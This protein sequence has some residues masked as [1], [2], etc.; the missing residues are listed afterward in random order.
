MIWQRLSWDTFDTKTGNT[1]LDNNK[2]LAQTRIC[3]KSA[4]TCSPSWQRLSELLALQSQ[5]S[6]ANGFSAFPI[7]RN[8]DAQ[9]HIIPLYEAINFFLMQQM[10]KAVV[11]YGPH[12][13]FTKE[14]LNAMTSSVENFIPYDW[15]ILIK[16]L[17]KPRKY[18]Q[19][20]MWFHD[21]ARDHANKNA[22]D[23]AS[24]NQ[25]IFEMLTD[26]RQ[27]DAIE[28][29]IQ[30]PPLLHEQLKTVALEVWDQITPQGEPT[31]SYTKILQGPNKNYSDFFS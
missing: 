29:Q 15:K 17:L 18:P 25:I 14:L 20:T 28:A 12:S 21:V 27:F 9:G 3:K 1:F 11:M 26:T 2:S 6:E 22:W 4:F 30:C 19:W 13:P 10:K 23:G 24:Q 16:A 31:G 5:V 7:L 8:P